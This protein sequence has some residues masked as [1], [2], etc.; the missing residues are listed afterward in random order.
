MPTPAF[1]AARPPEI[2]KAV[3]TFAARHPEILHY[4]PCF[5]GC[6]SRG[7]RG[8]DDCFISGRDANGRPQ[9][10]EHGVGCGVCLDVGRTAMQMYN[11]GASLSTIRAAIDGQYRNAFP[12]MTPTPPAPK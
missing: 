2:V 7:H 10:E 8:N 12:T 3:Y 11:S 5:C 6:E 9:W 1:M 4:L